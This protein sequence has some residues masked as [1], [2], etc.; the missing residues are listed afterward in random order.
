MVNLM[1]AYARSGGTILNRC[2]GAMSDTVVLSEVSPYRTKSVGY[3]YVTVW[4]QALH[5]FDIRLKE[6]EF[7]PALCELEEIC[8]RQGRVLV[9]REWTYINFNSHPSVLEYA[10]SN[11][12]A[13]L[14]LLKSGGR[15]VN[16]FVFLR[17]GL[18]VW[19]SFGMPAPEP[20]F[21]SYL[22]YL[23][24][25]LGLG[26]KTFRYEDFTTDP[27]GVMS[28]IAAE[29]G[30]ETANGWKDFSYYPDVLGDNAP[31]KGKRVSGREIRRPPRRTIP[32]WDQ[33]G[34]IRSDNYQE[35]CRMAGY[36]PLQSS[37]AGLSRQ[38]DAMTSHYA[39][40]ACRKG[41][42][43]W[44]LGKRYLM[45]VG[46]KAVSMTK[47]AG[48]RIAN[49]FSGEKVETLSDFRVLNSAGMGEFFD[50]RTDDLFAHA[51]QPY[52]ASFPERLDVLVD[53]L[54]DEQ[55]EIDV[56]IGTY[57][58]SE[59]AC[60][61]VENYLLLEEK[62]PIHVWLVE[63]SGDRDAYDALPNGDNISRVYLNTPLE[64]LLKT[65]GNRFYASNGCALSAQLGFHLGG[66]RLAFF[67][68]SDMM[69]YKKN[70]ISSFAERMGENTAMVASTLRHVYP[71]S[72]GTLYDKEWFSRCGSVD[73]LPLTRNVI[74]ME[75]F[76][77]L[78]GKA[79]NITWVDAGEQFVRAAV[80]GGAV[81][82]VFASRGATP[83]WFYDP[84]LWGEL[85]Y[86]DSDGT[87]IEYGRTNISRTEYVKRYPELYS[88]FPGWRKTFDDEGDVLFIHRGRGKDFSN[89][90]GFKTFLREFNEKA[91]SG[92]FHG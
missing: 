78:A 90:G 18:D 19:A 58:N 16:P 57:R 66:A 88:S 92:S 74:P 89:R 54:P 77:R 32:L 51:N 46:T 36:S 59:Q 67:S 27:D 63:T 45:G 7:L 12:L 38:L 83:Y 39:R 79:P 68:H 60:L 5:W 1:L 29:L 41:G 52:A 25:V 34:L 69:G 8:D 24:A 33:A 17:D 20:F 76:D 13:T 71:F 10:P 72:A 87:G 40:L 84:R 50:V 81:P 11:T 65:P 53:R 62:T 22:E 73:W 48:N 47:D 14:D 3:T 61:C 6:K 42:R 85:T 23:K 86:E 49:K 9:V 28:E 82:Y 2:I 91:R 26:C 64:C 44:G 70:F 75:R 55:P 80:R 43:M 15:E 21:Q 35:A 37:N 30:L 4:E 56:I 31:N